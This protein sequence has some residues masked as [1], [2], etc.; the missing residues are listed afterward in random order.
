MPRLGDK[1]M[2]SV[3]IL[4]LYWDIGSSKDVQGMQSCASL[5]YFIMALCGYGA[6]A[7]VPSLSLEKPLFIRE[8][9]DGCYSPG[10]YWVYK[11]T[12]EA[13]VTVCTCLLFAVI[14]FWSCSLRGSFL[15]F[16]V[17]YYACSMTGTILAYTI[18]SA[19]PSMEAANALL[20]TCKFISL[21]S[22]SE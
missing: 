8:R 10:S 7:V 17:T 19:V 4:S 20:P 12:E 16:V 5:L 15:L 14:I 1:I 11:L 6:A 2:F 3:I 9:N 22:S 13:V 18:A 21:V